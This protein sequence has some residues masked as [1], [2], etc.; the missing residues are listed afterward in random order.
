M[1][2]SVANDHASLPIA[3]RLYLAMMTPHNASQLKLGYR[4]GGR[5]AYEIIMRDW[6][7]RWPA[8]FTE[9]VPLA[10]GIARRRFDEGVTIPLSA[11]ETC[12]GAKVVASRA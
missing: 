2:L 3:Y 9:T 11:S 4:T 1:S 6:R 10:L 7:A 12:A 8:V 5:E